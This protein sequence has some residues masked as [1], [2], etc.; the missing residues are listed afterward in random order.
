MKPKKDELAALRAAHQEEYADEED[1]LV[2]MFN[3]VVDLMH[4]RDS[5]GVGIRFSET[6][7]TPYGPY[8]NKATAMKFGQRYANVLECDVFVQQLKAPSK[9]EDPTEEPVSD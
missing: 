8:Y 4:K 6:Q 7:V 3:T 2:G 5:W 1:Y 9:L